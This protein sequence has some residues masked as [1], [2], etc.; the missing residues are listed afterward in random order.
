MVVDILKRGADPN[1]IDI[2]GNTPL[3][4]VMKVFS[5]KAARSAMIAEHL[6]RRG[7]KPD[8]KNEDLWAPIHLAT[9]NAQ[10][11]ALRWVLEI[12]QQYV[13][14]KGEENIFIDVN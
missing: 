5:K 13:E 1:V 10:V 12:N 9:K 6:V 14:S 4:Q 7:A 8:V 2:E 11:D 3:H